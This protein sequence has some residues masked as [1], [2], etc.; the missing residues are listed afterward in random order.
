[1]A[2]GIGDMVNDCNTAKAG[3]DGKELRATS[4]KVSVAGVV[5]NFFVK[6]KKEGVWTNVIE[7]RAR[8]FQMERNSKEGKGR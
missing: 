1:M 4:K 2:P 3:T 7:N 8:K 5:E 6:M